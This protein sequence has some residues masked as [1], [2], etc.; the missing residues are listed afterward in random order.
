VHVTV[1]TALLLFLYAAALGI[2]VADPGS[3]ALAGAVVL[4][5]LL[6]RWAVRRHRSAV[7][8]TSPVQ[9]VV[10]PAPAPGR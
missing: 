7:R 2:A 3:R 6:V 10:P 9:P 4:V 5:G 1:P 8:T